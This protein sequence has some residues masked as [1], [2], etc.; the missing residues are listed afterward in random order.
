MR[1]SLLILSLVLFAVQAYANS[2]KSISELPPPCVTGS[3][4]V[5]NGSRCGSGSVAL[6]ITSVPSGFVVRWYDSSGTTVL[7]TS[8]GSLTWNTPTISST[9]TYKVAWY[10]VS[11]GC[12][13]TL[14][15]ITAT[16]NAPLSVNAGPDQTDAGTCGLTT[17][18][19]SASP[20]TG[21]WTSTGTGYSFGNTSSATTTFNGTAG[22]TYTLT[23]HA[24]A[25]VD[26]NGTDDVV[27]T[28]NR[29]PTPAPNAG[30]DQA[31]CG[32]ATTASLSGNT[33]TLG[34]GR[35]SLAVDS[36][37]G[38]SISP[39]N[40]ASSTL[41]GTSEVFTERFGLLPRVLACSVMK[42]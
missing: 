1:T 31:I 15:T 17:V 10:R 27:I 30:A 33:P 23:W 4:T 40:N 11:D 2:S 8:D 5:T 38:G 34:T 25:G 9:T 26:C 14:S 22:S 24:T 13:S 28:F 42:R 16:V 39:L 21:T 29:N 35:W 20:S 32:G 12:T 37:P 19:L 36:S 41:T 18:N 7:Y 6:A 3:P